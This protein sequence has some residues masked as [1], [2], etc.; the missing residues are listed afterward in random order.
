MGG[1]VSLEQNFSMEF[2]SEYHPRFKGELSITFVNRTQKSLSDYRILLMV[3]K[4]ILEPF[5]PANTTEHILRFVDG[6]DEVTLPLRNL[7]F[8]LMVCQDD[9]DEN[10]TDWDVKNSKSWITFDGAEFDAKVLSFKFC[11]I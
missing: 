6:S 5:T 3:K 7:G 2:Y 10:T 9:F 8:T 11:A 1:G 4:N